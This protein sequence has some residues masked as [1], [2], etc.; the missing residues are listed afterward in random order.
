MQWQAIPTP[1]SSYILQYYKYH[2]TD[3][4]ISSNVIIFICWR[5]DQWLRTECC[6]LLTGRWPSCI[7]SRTLYRTMFSQKLE[8]F[9]HMWAHECGPIIS[10]HTKQH[11]RNKRWLLLKPERLWSYV[12]SYIQRL[13]AELYWQFRLK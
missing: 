6:K 12:S 11:C 1:V 10:D 9:V 2:V 3:D 5:R 7:G 8:F 4:V 13:L